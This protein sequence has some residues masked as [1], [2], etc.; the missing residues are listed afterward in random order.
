MEGTEGIIFVRRGRCDSISD[1]VGVLDGDIS[2]Y[3]LMAHL[4]GNVSI[5]DIQYLERG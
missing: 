4:S 5:G 3:T 1:D 2:Q